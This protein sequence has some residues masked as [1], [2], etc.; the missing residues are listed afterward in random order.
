MNN[1]KVLI[2]E[3]TILIARHGRVGIIILNRPTQLNALKDALMDALARLYSVWM[4]TR[5]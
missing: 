3:S 4:V 2:S 1:Q 5:T